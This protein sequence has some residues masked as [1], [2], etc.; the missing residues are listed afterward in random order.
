MATIRLNN[1]HRHY[2]KGLMTTTV[3]C[4]AEKKALDKAFEKFWPLYRKM[5]EDRYPPKDMLVL[6]RYEKAHYA[7]ESKVQLT[8]GGI[9]M[10]RTTFPKEW[11]K[12]TAAEKMTVIPLVPLGG[13][14]YQNTTPHVLLADAKFTAAHQGWVV[15]L[16]VH[17]K[18]LSGKFRD[19]N[20]LIEASTTL[21][22]VEEVW[23]E[24]KVL[25]KRIEATLPVVLSDEVMARIREDAKTRAKVDNVEVSENFE[26]RPARKVVKST[27]Y[28]PED[29]DS[30][31]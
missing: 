23:P 17:E 11:D 16:D 1:E 15:A 10:V 2:L 7:T 6:Q 18:S 24:A 29:F 22:Q 28:E 4:P 30:H 3:G 19:Y 9:V 5:V 21:D 12:M 20:A 31:D 13:Y 14:H 27:V 8:E 26:R 25:R